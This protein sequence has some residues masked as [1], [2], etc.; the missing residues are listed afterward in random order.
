MDDRSSKIYFGLCMLVLIWIGVYWAWEPGQSDKPKI[1]IAPIQTTAQDDPEV[2]P[3]SQPVQQQPDTDPVEQSEPEILRP[4]IQSDELP[5]ANTGPRLIAPEFTTHTVIEG[6]ILQTIAE[7]YYGKSNMWNVIARANPRIDPLKLRE[8]MTLRIPKDPNNIQG[9]VDTSDSD[10][11]TLD[12]QE[13]IVDYIVQ[14]GD[15]L[16]L[17]AQRFYGSSKHA[18]F[19]YE[20]NRDIL[21]SMDD[22]SIGQTLK[23]PPLDP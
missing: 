22:I 21:R 17:I 18:R 19:I 12:Q 5:P 16:T 8:G 6:E 13:P 2:D 7:K 1:S 4:P 14:S 11:E 23:L 9:V 20:S 10:T 15:S 3:P